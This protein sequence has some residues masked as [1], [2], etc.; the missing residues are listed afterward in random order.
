MRLLKKIV[1]NNLDTLEGNVFERITGRGIILKGSKIL[2]L[3]TKVYNDYS[4]PGGGIDPEED[5]IQGLKREL[6][7]E[8]GAKNIKIINEF[9]FID[10]YR[11]HHKPEYDLMHLLSY[12]YICEIDEDFDNTKFE[13]YEVTNGMSPVWVEIDEAISHNKNVMAKKEASMGFSIQRETLALEL[14]ARELLGKK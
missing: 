11:P 4:F 6:S 14:I 2:L 10:E 1:N 12:F 5:I 7:E 3:Y 13:D 9:G 8:T